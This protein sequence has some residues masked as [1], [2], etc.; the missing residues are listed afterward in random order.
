MGEAG[1]EA[2]TEAKHNLAAVTDPAVTDDASAGYSVGS[3]WI[4]T[5][6]DEE[7]VCTDPTGGAAAWEHTTDTFVVGNQLA[8]GGGALNYT[9]NLYNASAGQPVYNQYTNFASGNAATDGTVVGLDASA[10][11]YITNKEAT[12]IRIAT[13][14]T[15]ADANLV[16]KSSGDVG[17]YPPNI[18]PALDRPVLHVDMGTTPRK[19]GIFDN[20]TPSGTVTAML[21]VYRGS[22][23][24]ADIWMGNSFTGRTD[25]FG[26]RVGI[27]GAGNG[28]IKNHNNALEFW[29]NNN[30]KLHINNTGDIYADAGITHLIYDAAPPVGF[31]QGAMPVI[32]AN[33][34]QHATLFDIDAVISTTWES[35]GPI[36]SGATNT[37]TAMNSVPLTAKFVILNIHNEIQGSTNSTSYESRLHARKTG[38]GTA[39]NDTTRISIAGFI[40]R[41]GLLEKDLNITSHIIPIDSQRRFDLYRLSLGTTPTINVKMNLVGW[42]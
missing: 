32:E 19:V 15:G 40:N 10:N 20:S 41:S 31:D 5:A 4:N 16:I 30:P 13:N 21:E 24:P 12:E 26:L 23:N 35:V 29:T 28:Y 42:L 39:V 14:E 34:G 9:L 8:I 38:D 6:T 1:I 37:W 33:T 22:A 25:S 3:R 7:Y 27:D 36:G 2:I 17:I 18:Y 11:F